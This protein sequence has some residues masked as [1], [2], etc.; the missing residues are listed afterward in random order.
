[1]KRSKIMKTINDTVST[2]KTT[3]SQE[4]VKKMF[5]NPDA[6]LAAVLTDIGC[7]VSDDTFTVK[8][9]RTYDDFEIE[10]EKRLEE[11]EEF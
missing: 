7:E 4:D 2:G 8:L 9:T 10:T 3:L 6:E 11:F 1:M 5:G